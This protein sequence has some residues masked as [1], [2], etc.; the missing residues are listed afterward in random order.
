MFNEIFNTLH[1]VN[2]A[3]FSLINAGPALQG[4]PL[5]AA[6][7]AAVW[8]IFIIPVTLLFL[9]LKGSI[10]YR[11]AAVEALAATVIGLTLNHFLGSFF[12][13]ARP[14]VQGIGHTYLEH[15]ASSSFPSNH[16]TIMFTVACTLAFNKS[17]AIRKIGFVLVMPAVIVAWAR[18]FVGVHWP[19]DMV[20]AVIM[21]T[22]LT[23]L[24]RISP[25]S[26]LT[27]ILVGKSVLL[28]RALFAKL[29]AR[30]W[31]VA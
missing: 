24:V 12:Y 29:I 28:Y 17:E 22:M 11:L 13:H 19:L 18:V 1:E 27:G 14:F 20:G 25:L 3:L 26:T 6:R 10:G 4:L 8:V 15:A 31:L 7:I 16:G 23:A 21:A 30:G 2:I 5:A 9:W